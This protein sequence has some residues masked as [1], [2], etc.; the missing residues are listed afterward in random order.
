M[1]AGVPTK[2][3]GAMAIT[4]V[5]RAANATAQLPEPRMIMVADHPMRVRAAGL[6]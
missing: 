5:L 3:A 1:E 6:D 4:F 2:C